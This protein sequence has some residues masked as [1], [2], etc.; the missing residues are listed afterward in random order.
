MLLNYKQ[1]EISLKVFAD[2]YHAFDHPG[3][4]IVELGYIVRSNPE[5]AAEARQITREFLD[6]WL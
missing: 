3:I 5:A 6:E 4:D 1:N 2:A